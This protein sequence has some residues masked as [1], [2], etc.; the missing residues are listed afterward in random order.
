MNENIVNKNLM[1]VIKMKYALALE[2]M[3][4]RV[5]STMPNNKDR[6]KLVWVFQQDATLQEDLNN[7]I[8]KERGKK[9]LTS[10]G[11]EV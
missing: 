6:S 5:V 11:T 2:S 7:L 4:H 3:G 9:N 8:R 1:V 10:H